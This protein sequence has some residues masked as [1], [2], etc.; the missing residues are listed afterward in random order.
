MEDCILIVEDEK[1]LLH[2]LKRMITTE[3]KSEVL[4]AANASEAIK[5][6]RHNS[7]DL[8]LSDIRMPDMDGL[9]LL[10][11]VKKIDPAI[12]VIMMTAFGSIELAVQ[13]IKDGAYDFIR[14]PLE[15]KKLFHLHCLI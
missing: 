7:I 6:I 12:T 10:R 5:I 2:G 15:E 11:E 9:T 14:K 3:I 4:T 1:D 13:S 8:L